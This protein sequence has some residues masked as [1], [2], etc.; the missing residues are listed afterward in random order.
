M[1]LNSAPL[2]ETVHALRD[3]Q[4]SLSLYL[5]QMAQ[6]IAAVNPAVEALLPEPARFD[7]LRREA[8]ALRAHAGAATS[9]PP[10]YGALVGIKDILRVDGFATQAGSKLPPERL[11]GPEAQ[12]VQQLRAAGA[13]IVGKTVTTEFAY[14]EPGPTRN[15]HNLNHT[16]GGSSSGSAAAVAAGLCQLALG[17]QTIGSVIRP[18]AFCGVVGFKPTFDRI[19]TNGLLYFSRTVD[20]IGLFTQ[21]VAGM[22]LAASILCADWQPVVSAARLPVLGVPVGPYLEQTEPDALLAFKRHLYLLAEA[23]YRIKQVPMFADISALNTLH[24]RLA[25]AEFAQEHAALYAEFAT[26]Y[27][28]RTVEIIEIGKTVGAEELAAARTNCLTLRAT[29]EEAMAQA[30]IDLWICPP[31]PGPAPAGI[32]ATGNPDLN[33]PWTHAGMPAVTIPAGYAENGL[34]LGVQLV[35]KVGTDELLLAWAQGIA[36]TNALLA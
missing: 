31:A 15:P 17:T 21:D 26:L 13:L 19:A 1:Y 24:R 12:C 34:P 29:L 7:R 25:F 22:R 36:A 3:D 10:L 8:Q 2:A 5:E 32:H 11:A 20:H 27:R 33:L 18:A 4:H 28:P 16:P 23:G 30:D 35:A 14:F 9:R 6:R